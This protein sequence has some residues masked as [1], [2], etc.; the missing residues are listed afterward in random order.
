[1]DR[2]RG[3]AAERLHYGSKLADRTVVYTH[4]EPGKLLALWAGKRIHRAGDIVLYT[5]DPG[6]LDGAVA[7]LARRNTMTVSVTERQLYLELNGTALSSAIG[8]HRIE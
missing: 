2:G 6:F 3:A 7:A 5:F 8:E 4:R 1:M